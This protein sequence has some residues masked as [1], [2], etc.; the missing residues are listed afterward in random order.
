M[1]A[2]NRKKSPKRRGLYALIMVGL[3]FLFLLCVWQRVQV[4]KLGYDMHWLKNEISLWESENYSLQ[5]EINGHASMEKIAYRARNR[6]GMVFPSRKEVLMLPNIE[7]RKKYFSGGFAWLLNKARNL[8]SIE[9]AEAEIF[10][11]EDK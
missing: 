1:K 5:R 7:E 11:F 6:L 9:R 10:T 4:A 2:H 3:F 8:F